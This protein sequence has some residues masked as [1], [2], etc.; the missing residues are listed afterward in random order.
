MQT[1]LEQARAVELTVMVWLPSLQAC[2]WLTL[3]VQRL[4]MQI[5]ALTLKPQFHK[6]LVAMR[7]LESFRTARCVQQVEPMRRHAS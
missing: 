1:R 6:P 3:C 5:I 4:Q 7:T 2:D